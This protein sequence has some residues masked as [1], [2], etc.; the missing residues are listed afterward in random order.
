MGAKLE[1]TFASA[2]EAL[3]AS[4]ALNN[5]VRMPWLGLGVFQ[6]RSDAETERVVRT[7]I[8]TG[9]RSIDTASLYGNERGVGQAV[10]ACGVPREALFVTT[11]VWND[12]MRRSRVEAAFDESLR[13]LGLDYVDL[14]LLH[15]PIRDRIVSSWKVLEQL[16]RGGRIKAIGVSNY[17]I[18]HLEELLPAAEV[19]PA[20]NQIEFHPYL[21]SKRL[22]A[23]CRDKGIQL[24]AWSPLMQAGALLHDPTLAAIA[25]K[26]GKTVAQVILRWDVQGGVVTIPK[27]VHAGR[28]AENA[29]VFDFELSADEMAAIAA[30][31]RNQRHGADP[32]N[33][34]F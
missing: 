34:S 33:F 19:V 25:R 4:V 12:D 2:A 13:R 31:D 21:Q 11:K 28:I 26:H 17:L 8:E 20:V 29:G 24:E 32:M 23:Y 5:S 9:Y 14:Y 1:G 27:S 3:K 6:I 30:L 10:R 22:A 18:P 15:W 7:A 16:H